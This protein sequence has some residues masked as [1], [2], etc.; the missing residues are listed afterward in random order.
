[1][2]CKVLSEGG[3]ELVE[4]IAW[5]EVGRGAPNPANQAA[6]GQD[7]TERLAQMERHHAHAVEQARQSAFREG[8]AAGRTRAAA[9]AQPVMEKL[10]RSI[11]ELA[12]LRPKLRR[13]AELDMLRLSLAVARRVLRRELAIDPEALHGLALAALEKLSL[14]E[15]QKIRVHPSMVQSIQN[16]LQKSP[17]NGVL[18]VVPDGAGAPGTL[19]FETS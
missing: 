14:Q 5:R 13:E 16:L 6:P 15:I 4:P 9:E 3:A 1:M 18:Q 19:V 7:F 8:E 2:S 17:A 12:L 10:A 11:E